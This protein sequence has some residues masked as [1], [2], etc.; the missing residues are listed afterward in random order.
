MAAD[1]FCG[2]I[3]KAVTSHKNTLLGT[4][5]GRKYRGKEE[6]GGSSIAWPIMGSHILYTRTAHA[7]RYSAIVPWQHHSRSQRFDPSGR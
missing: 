5:G 4:G 3:L 7:P 2:N 6:S 1:C